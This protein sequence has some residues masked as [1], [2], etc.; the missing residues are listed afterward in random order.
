MWAK[1]LVVTVGKN[2]QTNKQKKLTLLCFVALFSV[3]ASSKFGTSSAKRRHS[4]AYNWL[5]LGSSRALSTIWGGGLKEK[6]I[7]GFI[8]HDKML[9]I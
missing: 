2:N 1:V 9:K 5:Y 7:M 3:D 6:I 4:W 8:K